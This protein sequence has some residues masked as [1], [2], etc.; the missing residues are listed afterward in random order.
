LTCLL[1][2]VRHVHNEMVLHVESR[3][4]DVEIVNERIEVSDDD[5]FDL[6]FGMSFDH[7]F[8]DRWGVMLNADVAVFGDNDR[9]FSTEFRALYRFGSLNNV[10]FGYRYLR[11][12]ND[13]KTEDL[14]SK[15]DTTQH[16]PML[17]WAFTF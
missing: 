12:G 2:G 4:G 9:D 17:G 7:W 3:I 14:E 8:T 6:L 1:P 11:I 5:A 15:L 16:G 13:T 10:W